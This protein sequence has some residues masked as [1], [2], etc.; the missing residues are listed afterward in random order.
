MKCDQSTYTF[1]EKP[2]SIQDVIRDVERVQHAQTRFLFTFGTTK[3][4][5]STTLESAKSALTCLM[6]HWL[7]QNRQKLCSGGNGTHCFARKMSRDYEKRKPSPFLR[8]FF[9]QS[10]SS[11]PEILPRKKSFL[12]WHTRVN[13]PLIDRVNQNFLIRLILN[14]FSLQ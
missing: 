7:Y 4:L 1:E 6:F 13:L 12:F 5:V 11:T 9:C 8:N 3:I 10:Q 14:I 2:K